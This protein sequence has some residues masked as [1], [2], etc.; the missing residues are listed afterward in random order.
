MA[1]ENTEVVE[2]I[3]ETEENTEAIEENDVFEESSEVVEEIKETEESTEVVEET[4]VVEEN[5][6][7]IEENDVFEESTEVVEET[8][9]A[10]ENTEVIEETKVAEESTE[11]IEENDVFEESTEV[12]EETKVAEENTEV[13]EE[14]EVAEENTEVIE[15]TKVA[16]ENTE[17]VEETVVTDT[18]ENEP[19]LEETKA[20]AKESSE[21]KEDITLASPKYVSEQIDRIIAGYKTPEAEKTWLDFIV[22][23][24]LFP[25]GSL[26]E[27]A[28]ALTDTL[29]SIIKEAAGEFLTFDVSELTD[30]DGSR[31][32]VLTYRF[33]TPLAADMDRVF[34]TAMLLNTYSPLILKKFGLSLFKVYNFA[35]VFETARISY[36]S[37]SLAEFNS[38]FKTFMTTVFGMTEF[39]EGEPPTTLYV[40]DSV[41]YNLPTL[42]ETHSE[43]DSALTD[44]RL[45]EHNYVFGEIKEKLDRLNCI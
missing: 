12:V 8:K 26:P 11:V 6:E 2:E 16:E 7:V 4:K 31:N 14:T 44:A 9:V 5:T 22:V 38:D 3:K 25:S 23:H 35:S 20:E 28:A 30:E 41:I 17:V 29:S 32:T 43:D 42:R 15:E 33:V 18:T 36:P 45:T 13:I 1:E 21:E 24:T 34:N 37:L 40:S 19:L 39:Y 27:S 10:E